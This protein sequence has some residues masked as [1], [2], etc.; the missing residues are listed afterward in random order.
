MTQAQIELQN[1][2]TTTFLS[3]LAFLSEYD[4]ELYHRVDELSRM[5]ENGTY[6]EK[7]ALEFI[8]ESGDFDIYDIVNDKYLYNKNPIKMN[9][10]MLKK[11]NFDKKNSIFYLPE[12][13]M[14]REKYMF[15]KNKFNC[16]NRED[17]LSLTQNDM[18]EYSNALSD[19]L[20]NN[21]KLKE[22]NKFIFFGTLSGRHIPRIAKKINAKMYLV[23]ERNLE[24]FRLS[25]FTVDYTILLAEKGLIFSIMENEKIEEEKITKFIKLNSFYNYLIKISSTN[26]N[27]NSY[28]DKVLSIIFS[29]NSI[30][31]DYNRKLYSFINRTTKSLKNQ[32]NFI[33]FNQFTDN[34]LFEKLP[35]LYLAAGPSLDENLEW[36]KVNQN[37]FFIVTIGAIYAKLISNKIK[38]DMIITLD[39]DE[40]LSKLQFD[41]DSINL[42]N[43]NTIILASTITNEKILNKLNNKNL[44]LYEIFYS[45]HKDNKAFDGYSIGELALDILL[46]INAKNIYL[47]GLD[48][49][50][51]QETG[52]THSL[53][54]SSKSLNLKLERNLNRD[55]FSDTKS[56]IKVKGNKIKEVYTTSFFFSSIKNL[57]NKLVGKNTDT[58]IYN[59]SFCGAYFEGTIPTNIKDVKDMDDID[60]INLKLINA[61]KKNS[62][63]ELEKDSIN[64]INRIIQYLS[65][66]LKKHLYFIKNSQYN[67]YEELY[68]DLV[69]IPHMLDEN[70]IDLFFEII[71]NYFD[72]LIP[73]LSYHFNDLEIRDEKNKLK[74]IKEIFIKQIEKIIGDYIL[75]LERIIK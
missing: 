42:I 43:E 2:L 44:F 7:Y 8:M 74:S 69:L 19:Y 15:D 55:T 67:S 50:L 48:L 75:C 1:A 59:L 54:A 45:L 60:L 68:N 17:F 5:I 29:N 18:W 24:I 53:N 70:K 63:T 40:I 47:I 10:D 13:F 65:I 62:L 34:T 20:E 71:I 31:Y 9:D 4:N 26:L 56:L 52:S 66:E 37:K 25:L 3:N 28:I 57:E 41:D 14:I 36:I 58:K 16:E 61:L 6:K 73:Y 33:I 11:V 27:I 12:Y 49:A 23:L 72:M 38:V 35:I 22:I 21:K 46:K 32:Y 51:N 39:E 30:S 64:E